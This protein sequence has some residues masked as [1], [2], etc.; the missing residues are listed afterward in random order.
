MNVPVYGENKQIVSLLVATLDEFILR[1][2]AHSI[3]IGKIGESYVLPF[4]CN[5][6]NKFINYLYHRYNAV[7]PIKTIV[8]A[9][10]GIAKGE[11]NLQ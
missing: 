6:C 3:V 8:I 1:E 7:K 11:G 9:L 4:F 10:Q 5:C 2:R